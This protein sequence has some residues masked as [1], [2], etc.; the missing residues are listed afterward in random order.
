MAEVHINDVLNLSA[1]QG[2]M[3]DLITADPRRAWLRR[4]LCLVQG[5]LSP[6]HGANLGVTQRDLTIAIYSDL[7]KYIEN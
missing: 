7:T 6:E 3:A 4:G 5:H 1:G 2:L